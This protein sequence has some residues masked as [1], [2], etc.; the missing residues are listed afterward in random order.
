MTDQGLN[1]LVASTDCKAWIYAEDDARGPLVGAIPQL[2][3]CALPSVKWCLEVSERKR[4]PYNRTFEEAA[5]DKIVIIHTSGTTGKI[6]STFRKYA[7]SLQVSQSPS[8]T[9]M[10]YG[11]PWEPGQLS[12]KNTG[13]EVS[14]M[15]AG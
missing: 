2:Q 10:G 1:S 8:I 13:R 3:L 9:P 5:L 7:Y 14:H 4:Y 11:V 6:K 12:V 15:K